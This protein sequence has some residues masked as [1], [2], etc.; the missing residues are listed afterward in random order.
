MIRRVAA[1][2]AALAAAAVLS[3]GGGVAG[4]VTIHPGS[5]GFS[6]AAAHARRWFIFQARPGE[7]TRGELL[8]RDTGPEP[9]RIELAG[10]DAVTAGGGGYAFSS[11]A[12]S[13]TGSWLRL[14]RRSVTLRPGGS[15]VVPFTIAVPP[16][17]SPGEHFAGITAIDADEVAA[18]S[19]RRAALRHTGAVVLTR[20]GIAVQVDLPGAVVYR[21]AFRG[22]RL[23]VSPSGA[24]LVLQ[25]AN[26]GN[27][28][29]PSTRV[30]LVVRRGART[31][32]R[33]ETLL[34]AF[35]TDGG[36]DYEIPWQGTIASG[37]Y[38]ITGWLAPSRGARVP[39]TQTL[40]IADRS[41]H[42]LRRESPVTTVAASK[43]PA[44]PLVALGVAGVIIAGLGCAMVRGRRR[45]AV[46]LARL[47]TAQ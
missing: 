43:I 14:A 31:L 12:P 2:G 44:V 27:Q 24:R 20:A 4:A 29:I 11:F 28:L 25:I 10:T 6:I 5:L 45:A 46:S 1:T 32:F 41:I 47:P 23:A 42:E 30:H 40:R 34:G 38:H 36:L 22:A 19:A 33:S 8:V 17:A 9:K 26:T 21:L 13:H 18:V 7:L 37:R 3:F 35:L 39:L 16:D 15:A